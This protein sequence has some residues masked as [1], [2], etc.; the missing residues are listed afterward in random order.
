LTLYNENQIFNK[1]GDVIFSKSTISTDSGRWRSVIPGDR[2][3]LIGHSGTVIT[4]PRSDFHG[5][6]VALDITEG[7]LFLRDRVPTRR[8]STEYARGRYEGVE[9]AD[10]RFAERT[11]VAFRR[12]LDQVSARKCST[13]PER[14]RWSVERETVE[15]KLHALLS[16]AREAVPLSS[17][18]SLL[19]WAL[20]TTLL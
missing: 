6:G 5:G 12:G 11:G 7:K 20:G 4:M 18:N 2:D 3:Q 17:N 1:D 10:A 13:R 8:L 16:A 15:Q 14:V 19:E 9:A